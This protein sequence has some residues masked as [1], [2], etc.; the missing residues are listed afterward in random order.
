MEMQTYNCLFLWQKLLWN[1]K[2]P[3]T[4]AEAPPDFHEVEV[5]VEE[6][7]VHSPDVSQDGK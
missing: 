4:W 3:K 7:T 6:E 2:N 1:L 5:G